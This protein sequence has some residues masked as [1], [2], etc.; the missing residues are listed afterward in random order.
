QIQSA[1][2]LKNYFD[3]EKIALRAHRCDAWY[4]FYPDRIVMLVADPKEKHV[5]GMTVAA[6]RDVFDKGLSELKDILA[7]YELSGKDYQQTHA[8]FG[9]YQHTFVP[10][11]L[12][13][14]A[15]ASCY[16]QLVH[17]L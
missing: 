4:F 16:L 1:I 6:V 15:E 8:V 3:R 17:H 10:E 5:L 11:P 9:T 12:F 2:S 13:D 7:Q 14:P